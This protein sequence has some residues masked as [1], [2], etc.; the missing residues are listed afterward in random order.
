MHQLE[1]FGTGVG[2][3]RYSVQTENNLKFHAG[4]C[5]QQPDHT[6]SPLLGRALFAHQQTNFELAGNLSESTPDMCFNVGRER[7]RWRALHAANGLQN[8]NSNNMQPSL[9]ECDIGH[10]EIV[11]FKQQRKI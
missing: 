2:W 5:D 7:R 10:A 3:L 9:Q 1:Y 8:S 6:R 11:S 4:F